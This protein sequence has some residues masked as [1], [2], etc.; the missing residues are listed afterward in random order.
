MNAT[1]S[2]IE[3]LLISDDTTPL[4]AWGFADS[5]APGTSS[6]GLRTLR[7]QPITIIDAASGMV[8]AHRI[9]YCLKDISDFIDAIVSDR[10]HP[11]LAFSLERG[12]W[13]AKPIKR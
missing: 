4:C 9:T 2:P 7:S 13:A 1:P 8:I 3:E 6:P 5:S 12:V 11:K 10:N